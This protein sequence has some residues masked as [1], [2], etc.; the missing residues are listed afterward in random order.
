MKKTLKVTLIAALVTLMPGGGTAF[1][2]T[3]ANRGCLGADT[4]TYA[5]AGRSFG[6]LVAG[7]ATSEPHAIGEEPG[8]SRRRGRRRGVLQQ[9]QRLA[10]RGE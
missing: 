2:A 8:A 9:L 4:S 7:I 5:K 10:A 3:P 6:Q 1:A